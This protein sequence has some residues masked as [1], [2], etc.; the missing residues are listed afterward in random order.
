V[1][2]E[3]VW[4]FTAL[5]QIQALEDDG[6]VMRTSVIGIDDDRGMKVI[7]TIRTTATEEVTA[8]ADSYE[9]AREAANAQVPEGF[10]V[11]SYR[12]G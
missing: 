7:A 8:E 5:R 3:G 10:T 12:R 1:V 11:I 9:A 4:C 2:G 6:V